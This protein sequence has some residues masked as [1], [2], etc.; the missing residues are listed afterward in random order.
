MSHLREKLAWTLAAVL[1]L[2]VVASVTGVVSGGPLDPAEP[3]APTGRPLDELNGAWSQRLPANDAPVN[4][5]RPE[6][7]D[8][9][10]FKCIFDDEAVLDMETGLVWTRIL[11]PGQVPWGNARL[12]CAVEGAGNRAGWRLPTVEELAS[13]TLPF[14]TGGGPLLPSGHPFSNATADHPYWTSSPFDEFSV[15]V[16][17]LTNSAGSL[18]M[19][20]GEANYWCVRGGQG[21]EAAPSEP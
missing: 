20:G 18:T 6:G 11:Q 2:F 5:G 16:Y 13:L 14:G 21:G 12:F 19:V 9:S 8:S 3:P 4:P 7:C 1:A 17:W 10:R 15:W